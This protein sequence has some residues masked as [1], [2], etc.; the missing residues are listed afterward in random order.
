MPDF[1]TIIDEERKYY[2]DKKYIPR[3]EQGKPMIRR[4]PNKEKANNAISK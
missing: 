1:A 4:Y 3:D 2:M